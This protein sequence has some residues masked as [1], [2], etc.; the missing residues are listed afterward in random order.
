MGMTL[1]KSLKHWFYDR[2]PGVAGT[3]PY[4]GTKIRFR[5]GSMLFRVACE[6]GVYE[7]ANLDLLVGLARPGAWHFDV[8]CNI[9]LLAAPILARVPECRVLSF[10][11]SANVLPYLQRTAAE[12]PFADRWKVVPKAVGAQVGMVRFTLSS[13]LNSPYDGIR[14]TERVTSERQVE[15]ETTTIDAE[16]KRLGSPRV[17]GIKIDVEGGEL[18]VLRGAGECLKQEHP[19]VLL[20]WNSENLSAY[21][22]KPE[23]LLEFAKDIDWQIFAMPNLVEVQTRQELLLQM[24]R[25]ESFLLSPR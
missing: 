11:P 12:S 3:F 2:C 7:A 23:C 24:I 5:P 20:E 14:P 22:H 10:E 13:P 6:Q 19:P 9:G 15:V 1:R 21:K 4:Y 17:S 16:W 18:D 25:T 8:G